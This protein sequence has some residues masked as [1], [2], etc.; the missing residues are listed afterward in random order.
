[1][2]KGAYVTL[3][4]AYKND[5]TR[6]D[7]LTTRL[8]TLVSE[9]TLWEATAKEIKSILAKQKRAYK[10]RNAVGAQSSSSEPDLSKVKEWA[11]SN[12]G[13]RTA[14]TIIFYLLPQHT[15]LALRYVNALDFPRPAT[16]LRVIKPKGN[17]AGEAQIPVVITHLTAHI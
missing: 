8:F 17:R 10:K 6:L 11:L 5:V 4:T 9:T 15:T 14:T 16:L 3:D 13:P 2:L 7:I 12:A 1:M